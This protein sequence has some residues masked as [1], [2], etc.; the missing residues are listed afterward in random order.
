MYGQI[1]YL[2]F[3]LKYY[4][5]ITGLKF[6]VSMQKKPDWALGEKDGKAKS[7]SEAPAEAMEVSQSMCFIY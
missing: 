1:N 7:A 4:L 6:R 2:L 3:F 5:C